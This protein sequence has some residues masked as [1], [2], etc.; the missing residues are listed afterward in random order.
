MVRGVVYS[1]NCLKDDVRD[2]VVST[3]EEYVRR[4]GLWSEGLFVVCSE[5]YGSE[6]RSAML[7]IEEEFAHLVI[8]SSVERPDE[9]RLRM[10]R[11]LALLEALNNP[12]LVGAWTIPNEYLGKPLAKELSLALLNRVRDVVVASV[13]P[14]LLAEHFDPLSMGLNVGGRR[15]L[16]YLLSLDVPLSLEISGFED[17]GTTLYARVPRT[18]VFEEYDEYRQLVKRSLSFEHAYNLLQLF[19]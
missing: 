14:R 10:L 4:R 3:V 17:L 13:D 16:V 12:E 8:P 5:E 19:D 6:T 9:L 15:G 7:V 2:V 18:K 11:E 1:L